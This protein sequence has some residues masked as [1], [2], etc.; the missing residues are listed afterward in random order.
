MRPLRTRPLV[1]LGPALAA[2]TLTAAPAHAITGGTPTGNWG[3]H[4]QE[5][6]HIKLANGAGACTGTLI[7][8]DWLVTAARPRRS[9]GLGT[10]VSIS[11][12][13]SAPANLHFDP[14]GCQRV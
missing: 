11:G 4:Y 7:S 12:S 14:A 3:D 5:V 1:V 10:I 8:A 6:V 9:D 2:V 13:N